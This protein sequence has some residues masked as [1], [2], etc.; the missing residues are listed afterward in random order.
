MA[1]RIP[2]YPSKAHKSG[3]ARLRINGRDL[4][5]GRWNS[6]ESKAKYARLVAELAAAESLP[7]APQQQT[8]VVELINAFRQFA[9]KRYLKNGVQTSEVYLY[10]L[11]LGPVID[12]YGDTPAEKFGPLALLACRAELKR[13]GY[14]RTKINQHLGRIKRVW[15]WG[16]SRELVPLQ[17]YQSIC[18]VEG[19][20]VGEAPDLPK[21]TCVPH[22]KIDPIKDHVLPPV[23]AMVQLQLWS[24]MRPSEV[25]SMR[26][27]DIVADDPL[28][29][30]QLRGKVW[31]YRPHS[32]KTEH[33]E[34]SRLIFLGPQAQELLRSW[35]RP[36]HP[37][38]FL[39]SP[40]EGLEYR[41]AERSLERKTKIYT[42]YKRKR[43][44]GRAPRDFYE[45]H[46]YAVAVTRGC[47]LAFGMP[48]ELRSDQRTKR[49]ANDSPTVQKHLRAK[50]SAWRKKHCWSPNQLRHNAATLIRER[51]GIELARIILGHS[52]VATTEIYAEVDLKKAAT[53]ISTFG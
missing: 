30:P 13:R 45:P 41:R 6:P 46:A 28:I 2:S 40:R 23:W 38:A 16:A 42:P 53:A 25:C 12:L 51:Y 9:E 24:A 1:T 14:C 43:T 47:E 8:S 5:L 48:E 26:T 33:H 11:A 20:R 7:P 32:H 27:C 37:E 21:V 22:E 31:L 34:K 19:F 18:T 50:A 10:R 52:S 36:D 49:F 15:K 29:P 3:Q 17:T 4:W 44:P 35:L 39:F